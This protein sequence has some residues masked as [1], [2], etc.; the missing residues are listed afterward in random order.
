MNEPL[1]M[2]V[3]P[4]VSMRWADEGPM[5]SCWCILNEDMAEDEGLEDE[6]AVWWCCMYSERC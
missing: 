5:E 3:L 6:E 4:P 2:F 1:A